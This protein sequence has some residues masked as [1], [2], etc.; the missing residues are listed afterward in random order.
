VA[1]LLFRGR[2]GR[3]GITTVFANVILVAMAVGMAAS[4][5][6]MVSNLVAP[7]TPPTSTF[8]G[9]H[10]AGSYHAEAPG[11]CC[12]N[13]SFFQVVSTG[14]TLPSWGPEMQYQIVAISGQTLIRGDMVPAP[15]SDL[16]AGVSHSGPGFASIPVVGYIDVY[17][18]DQISEADTIQLYGMSE[19]YHGATF[20]LLSPTVVLTEVTIE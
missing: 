4:M 6:I 20:K 19:E 15:A 12:L 2:G 9:M 8:I 18:L 1:R 17:P 13:D 7:F 5:F 16:Y 3:S 14:G 10:G 11:Y